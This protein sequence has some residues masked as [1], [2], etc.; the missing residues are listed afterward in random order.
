MPAPRFQVGRAIWLAALALSLGLPSSGRAASISYGNFGPVVPGV[1]FIDVMESSTTDSVPLFGP[2]AP[3]S[4]GLDFDP[5]G[6][7]ASALGGAS[8]KTAGR[9]EFT[10]TTGPLLA[11]ANLELWEAGD[12]T[13]AGVGTSATQAMAGALI[14]ATVTQI[15]GVNVAPVALAP[16][17]ASLGFNLVANP[18][19]LQPWSLG[20]STNVA[21][22]LGPGLWATSIDVVIDNELGSVSQSGSLAFLAKKDFQFKVS[23]QAVPE[24][25]SLLLLTC[26][27]FLSIAVARRR[28]TSSGA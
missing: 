16:I 13:L 20:L 26:G 3:F 28:R 12:Y 15:N 25:S 5:A 19:V 22:Q 10:I 27:G 9:L 21:A 7:A 2:P 11:I 6:F 8:D 14:T 18:G 4:A 23:T 1:T 17:N 24:P